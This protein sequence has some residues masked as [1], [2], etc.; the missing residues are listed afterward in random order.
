MPC[1]MRRRRG[2]VRCGRTSWRRR[3]LVFVVAFERCR[4]PRLRC[5]TRTPAPLM[6][7]WRGDR[8]PGPTARDRRTNFAPVP[9]GAVRKKLWTQFDAA[10]ERLNVA[11]AG[12]SLAEIVA[13]YSALAEAAGALTE[14]LEA[15]GE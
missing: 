4:R 3:I 12:D 6:Q 15:A 7:V 5:A 2:P 8:S 10:V 13:A 14:A 1:A 9:A 11:G